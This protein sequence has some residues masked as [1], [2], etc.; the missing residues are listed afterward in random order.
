MKRIIASVFAAG[1]VTSGLAVSQAYAQGDVSAAFGCNRATFTNST[2]QTVT[3]NYGTA[4]SD[5]V[6]YLELPAGQTRTVT[7]QNRMFG[8]TARDSRGQDIATLDWPG[9]DLTAKCSTPSPT[10]TRFPTSAKENK[11]PKESRGGLAKT[12]F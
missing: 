9:V 5:D 8:Y 7:S 6:S 10:P 3:V 11:T 2:S 1:I 12:G 4:G